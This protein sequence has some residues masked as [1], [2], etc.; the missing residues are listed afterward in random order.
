MLFWV[1]FSL[2][3]S[4]RIMD[5]LKNENIFKLFVRLTIPS[6]VIVLVSGSYSIIDGVFW[7]SRWVQ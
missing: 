4:G 5:A 7:V 6:F 2:K 3:G 1:Y